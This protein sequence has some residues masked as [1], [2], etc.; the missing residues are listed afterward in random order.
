[1]KTILKSLDYQR[2][3]IQKAV[4][5]ISFKLNKNEIIGILGPMVVEKLQLLE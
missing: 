2:I 5:N 3:I 1:M 4:N